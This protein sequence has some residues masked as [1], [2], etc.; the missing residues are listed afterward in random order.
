M[1][2][3]PVL[4]R[5]NHCPICNGAMEEVIDLPKLPLTEHYEPYTDV[6]EPKGF[7]DN[8]LLYCEP[9]SH[10]KLETVIP[11][12]QLYAK[13]YLTKTGKSV[14]ASHSVLS[15]YSFINRHLDLS[16]YD[17]VMDIG[18]ND[19]SLLDLFQGKRRVAVDP[20]ASGDA[21]LI[22]GY[23]EH[24]DLQPFKK[25][26]KLIL[27]S[28]TLEHLENPG[29]LLDKVSNILCYGDACAFQ[30]P[31]LDSMVR[32]AR[33]DHV[34]H[35]HL[36]YFSLRSTSLLFAKH[37]FEITQF[38]FDESHYGTLRVIFRRGLEELKGFPISYESIARA[39]QDFIA[40][41]VC[42]DERIERL[43]DPVGFGAALMVPLLRYYVPNLD[44]LGCIYDQD[45]SKH[46]KRWINFDVP[47][48]PN[49]P[50][51]GL[52]VVVTA[53]NT[54]LA[55]RKIVNKL[56]NEGARTVLVPFHAL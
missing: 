53:F 17:V 45:E 9:C 37:G 56:T 3:G 50:V 42:F 51:A 25:D 12:E 44:R 36:H 16:N 52:D 34:H 35:Q 46:W 39:N 6:F 1:R 31:S 7:I 29:A 21:E 43:R 30:F 23:V 47:I 38:D 13:N 2:S 28:H 24:V 14:G 19:C 15:F 40:E 33:I 49:K 10:A 4:R 20:N 18:G 26:K 48:K 8:S 55:V 41:M 11:P 32:D 54:K 22:K 27:C 5:S